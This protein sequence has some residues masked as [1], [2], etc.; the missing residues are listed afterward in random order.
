LAA[1]VPKRLHYRIVRER[2]GLGI[3]RF[4]S[5][6]ENLTPLTG[7]LSAHLRGPNKVAATASDFEVDTA[8]LGISSEVIPRQAVTKVLKALQNVEHLEFDASPAKANPSARGY[9]I[10][11]EDEGPGCMVKGEQDPSIDEVFENGVVRIGNDFHP[12]HFP[13]LSET[14]ER[15]VRDGRLFGPQEFTTLAGE[16]L[17]QLRRKVPVVVRSK[18]LPETSF[19]KPRLEIRLTKEGETLHVQPRI[20][21][22]DPVVARVI[23]GKFT[24][25]GDE[26]P[27]R[28]TNEEYKLRDKLWQDLAI[29]LDKSLVFQGETAAKFVQRLSR[30]DGD[31]SGDGYEGF[32]PWAGLTGSFKIRKNNFEFEFKA[33]HNGESRHADPSR[34]MQAWRDGESL[35]PLIEGGFAPLPKDWINQYS[36]KIQDLIAAKENRKKPSK[37][38]MFAAANFAS[39][40]DG[41][42][43][44]ELQDVVDRIKNPQPIADIPEHLKETLRHYQTDGVQWIANLQSL[45]LGGVLADDMGLGKTLQAICLFKKQTL[46]IAPTSVIYNWEQEIA[47]FAPNLSSCLYH[48]GKRSLDEEADVIITS[49]GILRLDFDLLAKREWELIVLDEAQ[50]IKNPTSQSAQCA[51]GLTSRCNLALSGTPVENRLEDLW[52]L[53]EFTNPG[54]LGTLEFFKDHYAKPI[55]AGKENV[56]AMLRD[57][58]KP[59]ILRR[60][61]QDVAK[62]LPPRTDN[63]LYVELSDEERA[64]YRSI[65]AT[66]SKEVMEKLNEGASIFHLLEVLLRLR[67]AACH[68]ALLGTAAGSS[69]KSELLLERLETSIAAGQKALVFSQWTSLLDLI[70]KDL[71]A[72]SITYNRLDGSTRDRQSV[73]DSFQSDPNVSV[74]IMSLKA[75]GVG[76]NLTA[77]DQVYIVDPW[78]NP[79]AEDQ[80]A[81]RAHR[82]G[83][84]KPVMVYRLVAKDT[85]EE[86][87]LALQ[88]AKRE[89]SDSVISGTA[90]ANQ[91]SRDDLI[92]LLT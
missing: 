8:L 70:Q 4:V 9:H 49:Y 14:E 85:I 47:K 60:L 57:K 64:L 34:V 81:D 73:V 87:V 26:A 23:D 12:L 83:Q 61:K 62:E 65:E 44:D 51:Y 74:L 79:A 82:I 58:I 84:D 72:A 7:G 52:S 11:V 35:V 29:E 22:G 75:G 36:S 41:K 13:Q 56:S 69:S 68:G 88:H 19:A 21:Y 25:L 5:D 77:A 53:F 66:T 80:A 32:A 86:K 40:L 92:N 28:D 10:V 46:V 2:Q 67:Q 33:E 30:F 16:I 15:I 42:I 59:F 76:L 6:G 39:Q 45:G 48:G 20:A 54:Y 3:K 18:R 50:N 38:V 91:F 27:V 37:A 78:W 55:N 90:A 1:S 89:L 24:T 63:V 17:P 31:L 43:P 71:D